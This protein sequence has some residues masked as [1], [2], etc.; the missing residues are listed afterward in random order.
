LLF[1]L[2]LGYDYFA[3]VLH[4]GR[5]LFRVFNLLAFEL[6]AIQGPEWIIQ[7]FSHFVLVLGKVHQNSTLL[8]QGV[9]VPCLVTG[10][11]EDEIEESWFKFL[12][13]KITLKLV[14]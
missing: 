10:S 1:L 5:T 8:H 4:V 7:K 9:D 14:K 12:L 11:Q 13:G 6:F 3:D 2:L